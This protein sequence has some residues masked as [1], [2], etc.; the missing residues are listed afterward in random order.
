MAFLPG[1]LKRCE[2]GKDEQATTNLFRED[3]H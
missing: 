1:L 2:E 3:Q